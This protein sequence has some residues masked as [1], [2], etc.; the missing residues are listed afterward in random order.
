MR[1]MAAVV[2]QIAA[3]NPLQVA[4]VDDQKVVEA[5]GPDRPNEPLGVGIGVR[6]PERSA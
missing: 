6:G 5:L 2:P 3:K 1:T 4:C